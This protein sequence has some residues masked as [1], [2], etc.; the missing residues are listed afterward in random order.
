MNDPMTPDAYGV[1]TEP[2]TLEIQ[3]VLPGPVERVLAYLTESD[4]RRQWLASGVMEMR[5][6]AP[7]E[8]VW[9]NEELTDPPGTRPPGMSPEHRMQCRVIACE[10]PR[11]L[12]FAFGVSGEV[13]FTLEPRG[14][15][16]LLTVV[17][18]RIPDR[19]TL[20]KIGA[21]WHAHLDV[22]A[23]RLTGRPPVAYW[24]EWERLRQEYD[25]RVPV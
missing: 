13:S 22:L 17:H 15:R 10:A 18:R 24:D 21:G 6:G 7:F 9:R 12:V 3:R 5:E 11:R 16:V 23:A 20:L 14:E 25:R 8:L 4:L 1:L 2:A 19:D